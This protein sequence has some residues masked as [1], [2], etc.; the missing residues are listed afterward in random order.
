MTP[1]ASK[2]TREDAIRARVETVQAKHVKYEDDVYIYP[3]DEEKTHIV[4]CA[5]CL[6]SYSWP[7]TIAQQAADLTYLLEQNAR[8]RG[9]ID[10]L[11][12]EAIKVGH[13]NVDALCDDYC[14]TVNEYVAMRN[15]VIAARILI[16]LPAVLQVAEATAQ[17]TPDGA[18]IEETIEDVPVT[19]AYINERWNQLCEAL[20]ALKE[21]V[22]E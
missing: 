15:V 14:D 20:D 3:D 17:S 1:D 9:E 2:P 16:G 11:N 6:T 13:D 21:Q 22:H 7:C 4:K 8:L 12:G 18:I 5:A 10:R 19:Q